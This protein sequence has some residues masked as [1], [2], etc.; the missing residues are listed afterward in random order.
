LKQGGEGAADAAVFSEGQPGSTQLIFR[1]ERRG[2]GWG[3]E[4][5]P[6]VVMEERP[7][8]KKRAYSRP[9]PWQVGA[10]PGGCHA[11]HT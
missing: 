10:G 6:H 3:E 2:E 1:L 8:K 9:D 5:L 4:L 7:L 11:R